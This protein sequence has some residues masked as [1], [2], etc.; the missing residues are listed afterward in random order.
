MTRTTTLNE[1]K[2]KG[3]IL[4]IQSMRQYIVL[5]PKIQ[6]QLYEKVSS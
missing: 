6:S 1:P 3:L 5:A 2:I 4:I